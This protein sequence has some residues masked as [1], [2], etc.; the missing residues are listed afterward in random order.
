MGKLF[1]I[2]EDGCREFGTICRNSFIELRKIYYKLK[3]TIKKM[4]HIITRYDNRAFVLSIFSIILDGILIYFLDISELVIITII[5]QIFLILSVSRHTRELEDN[6]Y[7]YRYELFDT[8]YKYDVKLSIKMDDDFDY[9]FVLSKHN[10]KSEI[11]F[12]DDRFAKAYPYYDDDS[13]Y[14]ELLNI[15]KVFSE[16]CDE[17]EKE[18]ENENENK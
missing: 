3:K 14:E 1:E 12:T 17:K 11:S 2:I 8:L 13:T 7:Y 18:K 10:Y 4:S 5:Y 15:I 9:I 16:I 6:I